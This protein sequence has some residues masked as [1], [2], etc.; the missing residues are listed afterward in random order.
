MAFQAY[1]EDRSEEKGLKNDYLSWG[2]DNAHYAL[3]NEKPFPEGEERERINKAFDE[4]FEVFRKTGVLKRM[5]QVAKTRRLL[6]S[7]IPGFQRILKSEKLVG[8]DGDGRP[9]AA[10]DPADLEAAVQHEMREH[11]HDRQIATELAKDHL[12]EDPDYYRKLVLIEKGH[13]RVQ[14]ECGHMQTCKCREGHK[15]PIR[16]A[17][18]LC[19]ACRQKFGIRPGGPQLRGDRGAQRFLAR[20]MRGQV[21]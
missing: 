14:Y 5:A 20:M 3:F 21:K 18:G 13:G 17:Q 10:F 15:L 7:E 1:V 16:K 8:G 9:D 19:S 4:L 6:L 12:T 11:G 2:A